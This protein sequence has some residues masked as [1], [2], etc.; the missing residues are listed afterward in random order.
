MQKL[1]SD[2]ARKP[3]AP[4]KPPERKDAPE[5]KDPPAREAPVKDPESPAPQKAGGGGLLKSLFG[6]K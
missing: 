5:K 6:K 4:K 2:P 1:H 3:E